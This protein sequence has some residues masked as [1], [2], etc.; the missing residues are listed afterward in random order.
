MR[1]NV[2]DTDKKSILE[3]FQTALKTL[4]SENDSEKLAS[5]HSRAARAYMAI[6]NSSLGMGISEAIHHFRQALQIYTE[7]THRTEWA[8]TQAAL[9]EALC[10][11]GEQ[12]DVE[13]ALACVDKALNATDSG[14]SPASWGGCVLCKAVCLAMRKQGDRRANLD[15][16]A[17]LCKDALAVFSADRYAFCA[18]LSI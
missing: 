8:D 13:E 6:R 2:T 16:A 14:A 3:H 11:R 9:A 1:D 12:E 15:K 5:V 17:A 10:A 18:C 4:H 7:A